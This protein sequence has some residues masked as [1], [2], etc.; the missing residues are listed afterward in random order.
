MVRSLDQWRRGEATTVPA[1]IKPQLTKLVDE[2][3]EG[4]DWLH[5]IKFD[6]YPM[7]ARRDQAYGSV[8]RWFD[9]V[10]LGQGHRV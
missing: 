9:R 6:G 8:P 2:P 4:V 3:P 5:E 10:R 7:H 1:S